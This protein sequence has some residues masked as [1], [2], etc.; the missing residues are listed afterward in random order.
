MFDWLFLAVCPKMQCS[1]NTF[2]SKLGHNKAFSCLRNIFLTPLSC[3]SLQAHPWPCSFCLTVPMGETEGWYGGHDSCSLIHSCSLSRTE[4]V[5]GSTSRFWQFSSVSPPQL[6][7]VMLEVWPPALSP[8]PLAD[9]STSEGLCVF[10]VSSSH[11][12][13]PCV[14]LS[15]GANRASFSCLTCCRN[16]D[17][18]ECVGR[19]N[20]WLREEEKEEAGRQADAF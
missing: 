20:W 16:V 5:C 7:A 2:T 4:R 11:T 17:N 9:D 19:W 12:R 13:C 15:C 3:A 18:G 14:G 8:V 6:P 1:V 10:F